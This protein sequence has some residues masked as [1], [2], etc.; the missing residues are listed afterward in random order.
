MDNPSHVGDM[1][2]PPPGLPNNQLANHNAYLFVDTT[3]PIVNVFTLTRGLDPTT[4]ISTTITASD[5]DV[6]QNIYIM[7]SSTQTTKPAFMEIKVAGTQIPGNSSS[8]NVIGLSANTT[9]YGWAMAI[10]KSRSESVVVASTPT[11]L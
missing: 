8:Y 11:F 1:P 2:L 5:N 9:Y 4:A 10:D 3:I 7:V 6:V